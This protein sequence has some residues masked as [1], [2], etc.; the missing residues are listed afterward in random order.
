MSNSFLQVRSPQGAVQAT[1]GL[2]ALLAVGLPSPAFAREV[3]VPEPIFNAAAA[4]EFPQAIFDKIA[5]KITYQTTFQQVS[6]VG[7]IRWSTR[8][9][10]LVDFVKAPSQTY[11][12]TYLYAMRYVVS[13]IS[14]KD[15]LAV[16]GTSCQV[17]VVYKFAEYDEPTVVCEPVNL[18]RPGGTS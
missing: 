18:D 2:V 5:A 10:K 3:K 4:R 17:V 6:P 12:D 9:M 8:T 14:E 15:T 1:C 16:Y 7:L 13:V 11:Q